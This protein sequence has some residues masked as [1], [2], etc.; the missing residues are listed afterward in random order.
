MSPIE[1][2]LIVFACVFAGSLFGVHLGTVL[3]EH[4]MS[5]DTRDLV[6]VGMGLVATLT[7]LVLGLLIH[8]AKG[9]YDTQRSEVIRMSTKVVILDRV[10]S[11][12]GP[13]T[14]EVRDVLRKAVADALDRIWPDDRSQPSQRESAGTGWG[15]LH[16]KILELSPKDD[17]QRSLQAQASSIVT[18]LEQT[19]WLLF[20]QGG[21]S[22]STPL[23][24]VLVFWLTILFTSFGIFAPRN[25]TAIG[26][27]FV[28]ALSVSGAIFLILQ[29]D[30]PFGGL[31]KISN[32]PLHAALA[33]LGQ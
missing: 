29:L 31:I 28:C 11:H 3:P 19:R 7:A 14:K 17:A 13:E 20:E 16:N 32:A 4:H 25:A 18:D 22:I 33:Q 30:R 8:S 27:L 1:I 12:Y 6:K 5:G 24:G 9:S 10:L 26:T 15:V 2:S 23:L 21:S